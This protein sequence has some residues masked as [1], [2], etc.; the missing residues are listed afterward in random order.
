VFDALATSQP[1]Q[2]VLFFAPA[3]F[4][5]DEKDRLPDGLLRGVSEQPLG[6]FIPRGNHAVERLGD[7]G[8]VGRLDDRSEP[9]QKIVAL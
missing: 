7:D 3:I 4:R 9:R 8:V 5:N 2:H 1:R 6:A